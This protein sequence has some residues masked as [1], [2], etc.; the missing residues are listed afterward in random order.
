MESPSRFLPRNTFVR[1]ANEIL[2]KFMIFYTENKIDNL[3]CPK[4]GKGLYRSTYFEHYPTYPYGCFKCDE[5]FTEAEAIKHPPEDNKI[6]ES[7]P[8]SE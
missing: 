1:F 6:A 5:L 8:A 2:N 7:D 4:C 3:F